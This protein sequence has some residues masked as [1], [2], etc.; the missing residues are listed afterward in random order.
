M[1]Q[2]TIKPIVWSLLDKPQR[3]RERITRLIKAADPITL[4]GALLLLEQVE[5][6]KKIRDSYKA[7]LGA[8]K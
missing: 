7:E 6:Q 4:A 1:K 2:L 3:M 5:K 8:K